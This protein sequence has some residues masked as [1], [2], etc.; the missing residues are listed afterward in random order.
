MNKL[1]ANPLFLLFEYKISLISS[2]VCKFPKETTYLLLSLK[3]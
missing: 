3:E 2:T 1:V